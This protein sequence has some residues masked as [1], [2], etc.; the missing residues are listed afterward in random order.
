MQRLSRC[1]ELIS[2]IH[3]LITHKK[4]ALLSGFFND[5]YE[6]SNKID[7]TKKC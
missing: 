7:K 4:A 6:I 5:D 1:Q 2:Q 3:N